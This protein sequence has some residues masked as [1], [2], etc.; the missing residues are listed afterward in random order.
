MK[1]EL[2]KNAKR[3]VNQSIL[4][5]GTGRSGTS[6][7]GKIV[8]SFHNIEYT[9][10]PPMLF[11]IL[12]LVEKIS[13]EEWSLLFETFLYE[14]FFLNH[15][16]G[17]NMNF[18]SYDESSVLKVKSLEELENRKKKSFGKTELVKLASSH[19]I[20][21]K[22][23]EAAAY[24]DK[25]KKHYP[26]LSV[27]LVY[28]NLSDTVNSLLQKKWFTNESLET[29]DIVWPNRHLENTYVP[30]WVKEV[31]ISLWLGL[32]ELNRCVYYFIRMY[33]HFVSN[34]SNVFLVNYDEM[35]VSPN[36]IVQGMADNLGCKFGIYTDEI[37]KTIKRTDSYK[38]TL[39]LDNIDSNLLEQARVIEDYFTK[40]I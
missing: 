7:T 21:F 17:R 9:Y 6:I 22:V 33:E 34:L 15:L 12:P 37:L 38:E 39:I 18:N 24:I 1:L 2:N 19:R 14:E 8:A 32:T 35:V 27:I 20:A 30:F 28:R 4:V 3:A 29:G 36:S 10:E 23:P 13:E 31:D 26:D 40:L 16:A 11:S 5:C 25:I